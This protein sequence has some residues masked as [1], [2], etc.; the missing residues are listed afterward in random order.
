MIF[1]L[2]Y[3]S[4]NLDVILQPVISFSVVVTQLY[5]VK[6]STPENKGSFCLSNFR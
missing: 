2:L 1:L 6:V 5:S 3:V 4:D